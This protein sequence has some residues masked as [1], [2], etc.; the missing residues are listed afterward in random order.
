MQLTIQVTTTDET[1]QVT[2]NLFTMVSWE[3]KFKSKASNMGTQGIGMEDLAFLAYEAS[4]QNSIV[5]PAVFDDFIKKV[6]NLEVV[7]GDDAERPTNEA[8]TDER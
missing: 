2:T 6:V 7:G 8:P 5:V 3:R 4:K 1:Y